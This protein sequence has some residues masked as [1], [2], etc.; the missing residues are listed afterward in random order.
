MLKMIF[1]TLMTIVFGL[2]SQLAGAQDEALSDEV[3]YKN[4]DYKCQSGVKSFP[5]RTVIGDL[6]SGGTEVTTSIKVGQHNAPVEVKL[7]LKDAL[8]SEGKNGTVLWLPDVDAER[9]PIATVMKIFKE[10]LK[11]SDGDL[12]KIPARVEIKSGSCTADIKFDAIAPRVLAEEFVQD[13][14]MKI[15][16][17]EMTAECLR[18]VN[19][20]RVKAQFA[21]AYLCVLDEC[22]RMSSRLLADEQVRGAQSGYENKTRRY[23]IA[24]YQVQSKKERNVMSAVLRGTAGTKL[25]VLP[26]RSVEANFSINAAG[27]PSCVG[28]IQS[29]SIESDECFVKLHNGV[30]GSSVVYWLGAS[31]GIADIVKQGWSAGDVRFAPGTPSDQ[32]VD[33][34][35]KLDPDALATRNESRRLRLEAKRAA[36]WEMEE[37]PDISGKVFSVNLRRQREITRLRRLWNFPATPRAKKIEIGSELAN[38]MGQIVDYEFG[39]DFAALLVDADRGAEAV[40]VLK[41]IKPGSRAEEVRRLEAVIFLSVLNDDAEAAQIAS[42]ELKTLAPDVFEHA[43]R[44]FQTAMEF[45]NFDLAQSKMNEL[46]KKFANREWTQP[47][48]AELLEKTGRVDEAIASLKELM[49][50]GKLSIGGQN[51][52]AYVMATNRKDLKQALE[53]IETALQSSKGEAIQP[54]MIG[55]LGTIYLGLNKYSLAVENLREAYA[56]VKSNHELIS[57]LSEALLKSGDKQGA[58]VVLQNAASDPRI[59]KSKRQFF[60]KRAQELSQEVGARL[61][62]G[63][64]GTGE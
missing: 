36:R 50:S 1:R 33:S 42:D 45:G 59:A 20:P 48:R 53:I 41:R 2:N 11:K 24:S 15:K 3:A 13:A 43:S 52:L 64:K 7:Y 10:S 31:S 29:K 6:P 47:L 26:A 56:K 22:D 34:D 40:T 14:E 19:S 44:P 32:T 55:T 38:L 30:N 8:L 16:N 54:Y 62:A 49:D 39:T 4:R 46:E 12:L 63:T 27:E 35:S 61:P 57:D 5:S 23:G 25:C 60:G 28:S 21:S 51:T 9:F 37:R 18:K 17:I 58:M